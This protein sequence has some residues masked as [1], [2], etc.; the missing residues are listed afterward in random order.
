ML[1]D[2][3]GAVAIEAAARDRRRRWRAYHEEHDR[4]AREWAGRG[5]Q[6]PPPVYPRLP[7]DLIGL[8]CGAR[9]KAGS[10]CK[11][12]AIYINGRCKL[13]GGLST[14]TTSNE[15]R[16]RCREAAQ[17]RWAKVKAHGTP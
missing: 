7:R 6:Y 13:H 1:K 16:E 15:G 10:P 2:V 8:A 17:R 9:T 5:Y 4:I 12:A 3:K 14:G 11:L